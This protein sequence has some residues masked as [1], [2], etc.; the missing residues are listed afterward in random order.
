[1]KI[2]ILDTIEN[3][4][5]FEGTTPFNCVAVSF[6]KILKENL[7]G[8]KII[9]VYEEKTLYKDVSVS[10]VPDNV[11]QAAQTIYGQNAGTV[12]IRDPQDSKILAAKYKSIID[13]LSKGNQ[14]YLSTWNFGNQWEAT[15]LPEWYTGRVYKR[16]NGNL[17]FIIEWVEDQDMTYHQFWTFGTWGI[18]IDK[19][20]QIDKLIKISNPSLDQIREYMAT[21]FVTF[22]LSAEFDELM[23]LVKD[24]DFDQV[25]T[26]IK[27]HI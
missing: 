2:T 21:M 6:S 1:M 27:N 24:V 25:M 5:E 17:S 18:I 8:F 20:S 12:Q 7:T 9:K 10:D 23:I 11:R 22:Q 14:T 16:P 26:T 15:I 19:N 4:N 13:T 3:I